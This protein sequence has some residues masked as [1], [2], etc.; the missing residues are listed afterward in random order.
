MGATHGALDGSEE[1][2]VARLE[3]LGG[4][5]DGAGGGGGH[6]VL[7]GVAVQYCTIKYNT[8]PYSIVQYSTVNY[9][10]QQRVST[11]P[12]RTLDKSSRQHNLFGYHT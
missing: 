5:G 12:Q 11:M 2:P 1:E 7:Q 3:G 4:E 6:L 9:Q 8:V 10:S